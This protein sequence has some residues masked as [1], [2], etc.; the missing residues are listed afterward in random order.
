[1]IHTKNFMEK[2][3]QK[4][5]LESEEKKELQNLLTSWRSLEKI[6]KGTSILQSC[7]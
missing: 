7:V 4:L 1:M 5:K 6:C 2:K 3:K